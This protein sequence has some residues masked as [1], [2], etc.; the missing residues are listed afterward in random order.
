MEIIKQGL[1][2]TKAEA[3][4]LAAFA[5]TKTGGNVFRFVWFRSN[6]RELRITS[7]DGGRVLDVGWRVSSDQRLPEVDVGIDVGFLKKG[8]SLCKSA[9]AHRIVLDLEQ[10]RDAARGKS[11][12]RLEILDV[13]N[14][15]AG[16]P[17]RIGDWTQR[18]AAS[19]QLD[20]DVMSLR[21]HLEPAPATASVLRDVCMQPQ[22]LAALGLV[23][24]AAHKAHCR[25]H[26]PEGRCPAL[27]VLDD[28]VSGARWTVVLAQF[29]DS[30]S[31]V[32]HDRQDDAA[33][34]GGL[35][36]SLLD[37]P[38]R[39]ARRQRQQKPSKGGR[40]ATQPTT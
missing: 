35:Q 1:A 33:K 36:R 40:K 2:F 24:S 3:N 18:E 13:E 12:A 14:T 29:D 4:A 28:A 7:T 27:V 8:A 16:K 6:G 23:A 17:T 15:R 5:G 26:M 38:P 32:P 30:P 20:L 37:L 19:S 9:E 39:G 11:D 34:M 31:K 25:W 22:Y 10:L 21:K